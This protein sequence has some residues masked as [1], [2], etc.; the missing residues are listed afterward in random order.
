MNLH[1]NLTCTAPLCGAPWGCASVP[2]WRL[3]LP[4]ELRAD[5]AGSCSCLLS[6]Q[7]RMQVEGAKMIGGAVVW[8]RQ[9]MHGD[10]TMTRYC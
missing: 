10:V 6:Y 3:T 5:A 1:V 9:L 2:P 7:C 4:H 8:R